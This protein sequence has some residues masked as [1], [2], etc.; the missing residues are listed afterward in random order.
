MAVGDG[1]TWNEAL[2]DNSTLAHQID[3]YNRDLRVGIRS[4]MA[5]E[6]IFESSQTGTS[7]GGQH[8]YIT[9][10]QQ[11]AAPSLTAVGTVS[12]QVGAI[13]V[14]SSGDGY[15]LTF[16]NSAGTSVVLV[17]S[18][19]HIPVTTT[20]TQGGIPIC[21]SGTADEL[22]VL[23]AATD[24]FVLHTHTGTAD[25]SWAAIDLAGTS[26]VLTGVLAATYGGLGGK[27]ALASGTITAP[28]GTTAATFGITY[29][30]APDVILSW[31]GG[32]TANLQV[33]F[34]TGI[35]T[36]GFTISNDYGAVSVCWLARGTLA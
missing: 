20:G 32:P 25:P 4:R 27:I 14:G 9:F 33:L 29:A 13:F 30:T 5:K 23:A 36:T 19:G 6:H 12:T 22:A 3:D 10:Q 11:T 7:E 8:R 2:P 24:G 15:P 28:N 18:A 34:S 31:N 1:V 17:N 21:A 35:D 16:E 26:T